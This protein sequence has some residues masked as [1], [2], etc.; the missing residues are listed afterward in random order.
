MKNYI[1]SGVNF[2]NNLLLFVKNITLFCLLVC[3]LCSVLLLFGIGRFPEIVY[4]CV[5][6][7]KFT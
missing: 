3:M 2:E 4:M 5:N 1:L 7:E 6:V